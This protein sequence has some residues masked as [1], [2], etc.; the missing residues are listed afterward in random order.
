MGN[1]RGAV[2]LHVRLKDSIAPGTVV[3]EGLWPNDAFEDGRGI[4]TLTSA[5]PVAPYGG[6]A[7]HDTAVWVKRV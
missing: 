6:A 4:N 2:T 3:S 5:D 1:G 7:F